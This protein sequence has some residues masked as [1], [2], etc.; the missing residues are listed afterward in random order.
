MFTSLRHRL[1]FWFLV[2][3][4]SNLIIIF[5]S[6]SYIQ[7]REQIASVFQVIETTHKLLLED[8]KV[9]INFLTRDIRDTEF[10]ETGSTPNLQRHQFLVT[11]IQKALKELEGNQLIQRFSLQP[12]IIAIEKDLVIYDSVFTELI[13]KIRERGYKNHNK[14]GSMREAAHELENLNKINLVK[15][16]TLRRHEK[17]YLLRKQLE[18]VELLNSTAA[19]IKS[20]TVQSSLLDDEEKENTITLVNEYTRIFNQTVALDRVIG[21]NHNTGLSADLINRASSLESQFDAF[22]TKANDLRQSQFAKLKRFFWIGLL[23]FI[24]LGIWVS[25]I[26]A[27]R[28]TAPLTDLTTYITKFVD[29]NFTYT[30][31]K[32][33]QRTKDEIGKL[34]ANFDIMRDKIIEQLRFFKQKVEER[35]A[36]LADVNRKLVRI[37]EAN[38][39]F[40]PKE[41]LEY[42][43]KQSI[44]EVQLGDN[45]EQNMTVMFTDIRSFTQFSE[46][47]SP[48]E[49]FDFINAYLKH[50][51]PLVRK[52]NGFVD[53]YIGDSVMA[54]FPGSVDHAVD[55]A[56]DSQMAVNEFNE[57]RR[58]QNQ[59]SIVVGVG[60]HYGNLILGTIGE[61]TRMETTVISDA[62]NTASRMEGLTSIYGGNIVVSENVIQNIVDKE[63]YDIRY[64]DRVKAKG[65]EKSIA[66]YEVLTGLP[67]QELELKLRMNGRFQE[68]IDHYCNRAFADAKKILQELRKEN[69]SDLAIYVYLQR[70]EDLLSNGVPENWEATEKMKVKRK[71]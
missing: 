28:I 8:S 64:L 1:L 16:L 14:I 21:L 67:E 71:D 36:E 35:T 55:A 54:L 41:F 4:S 33:I 62:V 20:E 15:L 42:L 27:K 58:N 29:S 5:F 69:G 48:Q 37:N 18:Y 9:E 43:Q 6:L 59:E 31:Q 12:D 19:E 17:D 49:N 50:T 13:G 66:V 7:Q 61:E 11:T 70:C 63:K 53:K 47:M 3:V 44:E 39:R 10:Y 45:V 25:F 60:M 56:I 57:F 22:L 65:K 46:K 38:S 34:T 23:V 2:F 26:M 24:L 52:N 68:A 30:G 40:V 32:K 51:V